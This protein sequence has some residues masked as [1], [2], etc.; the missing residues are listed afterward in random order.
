MKLRLL[1]LVLPVL[2]WH[3]C[4]PALPIGPVVEKDKEFDTYWHQDKAEITSYD[5]YQARYGEMREG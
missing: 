4:Q 3:S 5:L 2:A 1:F